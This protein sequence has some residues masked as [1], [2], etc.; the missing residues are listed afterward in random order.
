MATM[1]VRNL[2]T[3]FPSFQMRPVKPNEYKNKIVGFRY[4]VLA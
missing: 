4:I 1:T 3:T 2:L